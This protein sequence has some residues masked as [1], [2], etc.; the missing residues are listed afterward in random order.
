[1]IT[2]SVLFDLISLNFLL[3]AKYVVLY[4]QKWNTELVNDLIS[5]IGNYILGDDKMR[6]IG[7]IKGW[8]Y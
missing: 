7:C 5:E 1:M 8:L 3:T 6:H 4:F 2:V